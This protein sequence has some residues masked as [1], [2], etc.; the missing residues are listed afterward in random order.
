MSSK[1]ARK[2]VVGMANYW[3]KKA[4]KGLPEYTYTKLEGIDDWIWGVN[5]HGDV[6]YCPVYKERNMPETIKLAAEMGCKLYRVNQHYNTDEEVRFLDALVA[7]T[8][9][10]GMDIM[11]VLE[12]QNP[13]LVKTIAERYNGK[14]G[15]GTIKY[16]QIHNE[17]SGYYVKY[18]S[19][20]RCN[21]GYD[22]EKMAKYLKMF[23]DCSAVI[24]E[25]HPECKIVINS[26]S[27]SDYVFKIL[28]EEGIDFDVI[29]HDWY[30]R[31][32]RV[33]PITDILDFLVTLGK[34]III[35]EINTFPLFDLE[36]ETQRRTI[37]K[38]DVND[39]FLPN[40]SKRI[41]EYAKTHPLVKGL[42]I[43]ELLDEPFDGY[44]ERDDKIHGEAHFGIVHAYANGDLGKPKPVYYRM[45]KLMGGKPIK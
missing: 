8:A 19:S 12:D 20:G 22:R 40:V 26:A 18:W 4:N 5:G 31:D 38:L 6:P 11:L 33:S 13:E 29:G 14:N 2:F 39:K 37:E 41:Y 15:H 44:P 21:E 10:Y 1:L 30:S 35:C 24:R 7:E 9:K 17:S 27:F 42:V 43:Y 28:I 23:R 34:E 45:Q 25:V 3:N 16:L 32:E 36:V